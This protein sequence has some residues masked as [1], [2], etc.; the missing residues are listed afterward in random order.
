MEYQQGHPWIP[1][2]N[3]WKSINK[4]WVIINV[5]QHVWSTGLVAPFLLKGRLTIQQ[6]CRDRPGWDEPINEKSSYEWLKWKKYLGGNEKYQ[7][8]KML[9]TNWLQPD[10]RIHLTSLFR[11]KWNWIW[12]YNGI[13]YPL[14]VSSADYG[15][16]GLD[17]KNLEKT[18]RWFSGSSF[19][20]SK[21]RDWRSSGNINPVSKKDAELRKEVRVNFTVTDD[22]IISRIGLLTTRW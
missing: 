21:N 20:W 18:H 17:V 16:R 7:Y 19:L 6:L 14:R 9:Q 4:T 22:T 3:G 8:T 10:Y 1:N 5:K 2:E 11:C 13:T 15:S 12:S